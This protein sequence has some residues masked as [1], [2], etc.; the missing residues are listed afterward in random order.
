MKDISGETLR[1]HPHQDALIPFGHIAE[2]ERNVLVRI[3][4]VAISDYAPDSE[5]SR[6]TRFCNAMDESLGFE[7]VRNKL[8]NSY[9][10]EVVLRGKLLELR[11]A[12][13]C[14]VLIQDL[15]NDSVGINACKPRQI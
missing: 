1:V 14:A 7:P 8:R 5:F 4:I 9:E 2:Y 15:A 10:R 6:Q 11:A 12:C 13:S 3:D